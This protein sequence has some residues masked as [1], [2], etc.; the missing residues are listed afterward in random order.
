MGDKHFVVTG[1]E[2]VLQKD[3][4]KAGLAVL[5]VAAAW[6]SGCLVRRPPR[7]SISQM[8]SLRA[9]VMPARTGAELDAPPEIAM[10]TVEAPEIAIVRNAPARPR[11]ATPL[12]SEPNKPEK[13]P[14]PQIAPEVSSAEMNAARADT[15]RNLD[16]T[17]KNLSAALGRTLNASQ[18]DLISKVRGFAE[19]AREAMRNGDWVRAKNFSKKAEVL[20]EEL[21]DSL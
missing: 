1:R 21:A 4:T 16:A 8:V 20:S 18:Q 7:S 15:Q 5:C 19:N 10:D 14:E 3:K 9:P 2:M 12:A 13:G 11:V 17:E 6:T